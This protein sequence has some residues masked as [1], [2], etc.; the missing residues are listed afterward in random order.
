[1]D[2]IDRESARLFARSKGPVRQD[3]ERLRIEDRDLTLVLDVR[4]DLAAIAD[5][6]LR[7]AAE[8][9]GTN[10]GAIRGVDRR[11]VGAA[12]AMTL[13]ASSVVHAQAAPGYHV[14]HRINAG[15][16]GGWDYVTVDPESN[17]SAFA[18]GVDA[19]DDVIAGRSL[20]VHDR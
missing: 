17:R 18:A 6:G 7:R 20:R 8:S 10:D 5:C 19:V 12:A 14:I 1:M 2:A 16:E 15:G 13:A 4:V 11:R 9:Y 3:R